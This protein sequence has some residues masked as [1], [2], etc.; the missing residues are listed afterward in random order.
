M[1]MIAFAGLAKAGKSTLSKH[2][3]TQG[4][5]LHPQSQTLRSFAE[6]IKHSL[7][8][9]GVRKETHP[10]VY[11]EIAQFI[12][13]RMREHDPDHWVKQ[14]DLRVQE[15]KHFAKVLWN[16]DTRYINEIEYFKKHNGVLVFV[17]AKTRINPDFNKFP[18][19]HASERIA[20]EFYE[21]EEIRNMFDVV[22]D[23]NSGVDAAIGEITEKVLKYTF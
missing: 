22:I 7:N 19:N 1:K 18:Y 5:L 20:K 4:N 14:F 13:N 16:D 2:C 21:K 6:P 12:G 15:D 23:G 17:D 9:F 11:R 8:V 3:L 10:V